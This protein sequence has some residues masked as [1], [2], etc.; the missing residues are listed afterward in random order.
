V[1]NPPAVKIAA[2]E[3]WLWIM[4]ERQGAKA[5]ATASAMAKHAKA[6]ILLTN[7]S[8]TLDASDAKSLRPEARVQI[9]TAAGATT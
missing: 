2:V 1:N 6:T 4:R 8:P 5:A 3:S 9:A 7:A